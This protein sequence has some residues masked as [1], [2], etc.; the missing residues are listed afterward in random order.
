MRGR[1]LA[2]WGL[3][4]RACPAL[5]AVLLGTAGEAWGMRWPT[6]CAVAGAAILVAWAFVRIPRW[7][8]HLERN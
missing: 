8:T 4:T 6:L 2:L 5:G 1:T 7:A 3:I